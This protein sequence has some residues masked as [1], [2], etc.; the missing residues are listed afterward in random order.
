MNPKLLEMSP[1]QYLCPSCGQWHPTN[2]SARLG[3]FVSERRSF[4][5]E[6]PRLSS[7]DY[8][9]QFTCYVSGDSLYYSTGAMCGA[10][11]RINGKI[12]LS[13]IVED[14]EE[15]VVTFDVA[16]TASREVG[17]YECRYCYSKNVCQL[18]KLGDENDN[19]HM[20]LKFGFKFDKEDFEQN[21]S[22]GIL[23]KKVRE[24]EAL[25][26]KLENL[27]TNLT[28]RETA[29]TAREEALEADKV[30]LKNAQDEF[31]NKKLEEATKMSDNTKKTSIFTQLYEHSPKENVAL[32]KEWASKYQPV[33]RWAIPAGAVF[34]AYQI[35]KSA[36]CDLNVTNISETCEK[37]LGF[38]LEALENKRALK[39]LLTIGGL[40]AG[41]YTAVKGISTIFGTKESNTDISVEDMEAGMN[42]LEAV[43]N[44]FAWIQPKTEDL[45]PIAFSV[46][47]VYVTL[48]KPKFVDTLGNKFKGLTE[49]LQIRIGTYLDLAKLFIQDKFNM[50]L[51]CEEDQRKVKICVFLVALLGIFAFLYGKKV[52]KDK[53]ST[54]ETDSKNV[55]TSI[56]EFIAQAKVIL[57]KIAPTA[58]TTLLAFLS[59]KMIL[60]LEEPSTPA[61]EEA[62]IVDADSN[63]GDDTIVEEAPAETGDSAN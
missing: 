40:T 12:P 4:K 5:Q 23:N 53:N 3:Y 49:D 41:A 62:V 18:A 56:E 34:A 14:A 30:A 15:P 9:D 28:K 46:I 21:S 22:I 29:L 25:R 8:S 39:E 58:Y 45:L 54:E 13:S 42:Q 57:E 47:L 55:S 37:K 27:S 61:V 1:T 17:H 10:D 59:S 24:T 2:S 33:L 48:H 16:F 31:N 11:R 26:T 35:L 20:V 52:L 63:N 19:R 51:S 38:K 32:V 60:K 44:K 50:D 43:S 6:C 36:D 7:T